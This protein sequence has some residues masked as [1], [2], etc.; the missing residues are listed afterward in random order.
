MSSLTREELERY[1]R[2]IVLRHVGGPGQAKLRKA[3]VLV[4]GAGGLGSPAL[5]Y[6]IAVG[7]GCIGVADD[8]IVSLSNLQRQTIHRTHAIGQAKTESVVAFAQELNPDVRIVPHVIRINTNNA[9]TLLA[10]YDVVLDG[11]DNFETR[12]CVSDACFYLRKPLITAAVNEFD[13]SIT[14]LKPF[15]AGPDGTPN[16]TYR[17]LFPDIPTPGTIQ[18]CSEVGVLGALT[19]VVGALQAMEAIREIVGFGETLVGHLLLIDALNLRFDKIAYRWDPDNPLNGRR[20]R[21]QPA[22]DQRL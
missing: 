11:S 12:F 13:A 22:N 6:L 2:H 21:L 19:G 9:A 14:V 4:I 7:V 3:R 20:A 17:C 10:D 16:P 15:E 1:A 5:Q 8:D 18:A